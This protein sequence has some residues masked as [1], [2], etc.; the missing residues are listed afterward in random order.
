MELK[1]IK[2]ARQKPQIVF[3]ALNLITR[4]YIIQMISITVDFYKVDH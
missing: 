2:Y 4:G 3:K 1:I